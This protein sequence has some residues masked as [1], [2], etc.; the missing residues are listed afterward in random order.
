MKKSTEI[1]KSS[2]YAL[3]EAL[4]NPYYY[5]VCDPRY[6]FDA[7]AEITLGDL[8]ANL[9]ILINMGI[10]HGLYTLSQEAWQRL[11]AIFFEKP[12]H[13]T[14]ALQETFRKTLDEAIIS[15]E[16]SQ[17]LLRL[18]GDEIADRCGCDLL[19]LYFLEFL[20]KNNIQYRIMLSNHGYEAIH[21]LEENSRFKGHC[22]GTGAE[23]SEENPF[24]QS[25]LSLQKVMDCKHIS[26]EKV[27][28]L[29]STCYFP[30]LACIDYS[31][32]KDNQL[33]WY[34][35][36]YTTLH[37]LARL[38]KDFKI[39]EA[40]T[41][42]TGNLDAQIAVL[43]AVQEKFTQIVKDRHIS[44]FVR[45]GS[46]GKPWNAHWSPLGWMIWTRFL[47]PM[48]N[49]W[50]DQIFHVNGH[51]NLESRL[52]PN[53]LVLNPE[54]GFVKM[55]LE[56]IR[57]AFEVNRLYYSHESKKRKHW[58][59]REAF[60]KLKSKTL[61]ADFDEAE[62]SLILNEENIY[63]SWAIDTLDFL[64]FDEENTR[65]FWK[66]VFSLG[67]EG[68]R[69]RKLILSDVSFRDILYLLHKIG[70][71]TAENMQLIADNAL[72][73]PQ[74]VFASLL[75]AKAI[76][77]EDLTRLLKVPSALK[78]DVYL[79]LSRLIEDNS[80]PLQASFDSI[81]T[82][83]VAPVCEQI[84]PF[85]PRNFDCV[86]FV[87]SFIDEFKIH[88]DSG[89]KI[90]ESDVKAILEDFFQSQLPGVYSQHS[91]NSLVSCYGF[92]KHFETVQDIGYHLAFLL[93]ERNLSNAMAIWDF[94]NPDYLN[95]KQLRF[96]F[97]PKNFHQVFLWF[98]F[99]QKQDC[100]S[101]KN[102]YIG[103]CLRAI[104]LL[105][106]Q[107]IVLVKTNPEVILDYI[108]K[109]LETNLCTEANIKKLE[110]LTQGFS[111]I[112]SFNELKPQLLKVVSEKEESC[113][114]IKLS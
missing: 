78:G 42:L 83:Y 85:M 2:P 77:P 30:H 100:L 49:P 110:E 102:L 51:H 66:R 33:T 60:E 6:P 69:I 112:K 61:Q 68:M 55:P 53:Y 94:L 113:K 20:K 67:K 84:A 12:E 93:E 10:Y 99:L 54:Y 47:E 27:E 72:E 11:R 8:H 21:N 79:I 15:K 64:L 34:T 82:L 41:I 52:P 74:H 29:F 43:D 26:R 58:H 18:L 40:E 76:A 103:S 98:R 114:I 37:T 96:I 45:I 109:L 44:S 71:D 104:K 39:P 23:S 13:L 38:A 107:L 65:S 106:A 101:A 5:P 75:I 56:K 59:F 14:P 50:D 63:S 1:A 19:T 111:L 95:E 73:N 62:L 80:V 92:L 81:A 57:S 28:G 87:D 4:Q 88:L 91:L 7:G 105:S 70:A 16:N 36:S 17:G 86:D 32:S 97:S 89:Q 24:I 48:R 3:F 90:R 22:I 9:M 31:L 25:L 35:H 46:V 108:G